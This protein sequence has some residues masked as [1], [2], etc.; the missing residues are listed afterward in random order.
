LAESGPDIG[1]APH[2][3]FGTLLVGHAEAERGFAAAIRSGRL[4]HAW[5]IGGRAG[6]GKATLAYRAARRLLAAP[7][8]I[9]G[10][11]DSLATDPGGRTARQIAAGSHPNLFVLDLE[12]ASADVERPPA[13]TIPV[14]TT[15]RV[16]AFFGTTAANGG[17]RVMIV[18]CAE[19][20]TVQSANALLKTI[21]EPPPRSIILIVSHAPQRVLPTIRSRCRKLNLSPLSGERVLEALRTFLPNGEGGPDLLARAAERAD[22][23]VRRAL[24]LLDPKRQAILD[25]LASLLAALPEV[26]MLRVL[27]LAEKLADR[28]AEGDFE[29]AVDAVQL[30]AAERIR[31]GADLGPARLAP[32][33][34]LCEKVAD[35]ARTVETYNLDRRPFVV[36]MFGDLAE[37]VRKAA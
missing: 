31:A 32:L 17:H 22:G 19:D 36:S 16:L 28:R 37:V 30:W 25:E 27:G 18:D 20:L 15:R 33:A 4:H 29:L 10:G 3:R 11:E 8:E 34:E 35:A 7:D 5:L 26:P 12:I 1:E 9:R 13:K 24:T 23:S 21:E 2:P 6:I 14:K